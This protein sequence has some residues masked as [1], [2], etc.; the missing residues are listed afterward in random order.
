MTREL[1]A[2]KNA[3]R[4]GE[5]AD[6]YDAVRPACPGYAVDILTRYLGRPPQTVVDIGCG[7]AWRGSKMSSTPEHCAIPRLR[8][9]QNGMSLRDAPSPPAGD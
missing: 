7:W 6:L 1:Q 4:F 8:S 2:H 3:A 9:L 5:F